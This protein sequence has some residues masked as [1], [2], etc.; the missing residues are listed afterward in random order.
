MK[1]AFLVILVTISVVFSGCSSYISTVDYLQPTAKT[2]MAQGIS[3]TSD[4]HFNDARIYF[5]TII[6]ADARREIQADQLED[7]LVGGY[8]TDEELMSISENRSVVKK[9]FVITDEDNDG[10]ADLIQLSRRHNFHIYYRG[11]LSQKRF[12]RNPSGFKH[13]IDSREIAESELGEIGNNESYSL[14]F[15]PNSAT[16]L[17]NLFELAD[18]I[19]KS[20]SRPDIS[21]EMSQY[22]VEL[23]S[24]L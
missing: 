3:I 7:D 5:G 22:S 9:Y 23:L 18:K 14:T 12:M 24:S 15:I 6:L 19:I 11:N 16:D 20:D 10:H 2:V 1:S 21:E 4:L 8:Y 17:Q 13:P